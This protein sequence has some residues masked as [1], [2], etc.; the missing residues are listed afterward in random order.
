MLYQKGTVRRIPFPHYHASLKRRKTEG[1]GVKA[2]IKLVSPV[3]GI[4]RKEINQ[5]KILRQ[6][7][8]IC[9]V[10]KNKGH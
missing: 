8:E 3:A 6:E 7:I 9:V 2:L 1:G 5:L 10:F 4:E